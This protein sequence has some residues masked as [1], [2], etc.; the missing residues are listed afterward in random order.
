MS[1][2]ASI[3]VYAVMFALALVLC[4]CVCLPSGLPF[5]EYQEYTSAVNLIQGDAMFTDYQQAKYRVIDTENINDVASAIKARL[6]SIYG[7]Y[8]SNVQVD[9][10]EIIVNVPVTANANNTSASSI[11]SAVTTTGKVEIT[12][13]STY[14]SSV[15]VLTSEHFKSASFRRYTDSSTLYYVVTVN[16]NSEGVEAASSSLTVATSST[17]GYLAIDETVNSSSYGVYYTAE[18]TIQIYTVSDSYGKNLVG[19]INSGALGSALVEIPMDNSEEPNIVE[20]NGGLI[21][22]IV[23]AVVILANWIFYFAKYGKLAFAPILS[24]LIAVVVFI[25]FAGYVYFALLNIASAIGILLGYALMSVFTVLV[26]ERIAAYSADK[27]TFSTSRHKGFGDFNKWN[28]IVHAIVLVVGAILWLIPTGVTAPLGN[29]LVY[30]AV[31][32]F[33]VTMGLNRLFT[34]LVANF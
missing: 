24:Q 22:G 19:L 17:A 1:K 12:S 21:F 15:V 20:S 10:D 4:V 6:S 29:A 25:L 33:C 30:G 34:S 8:F 9:G 3:V 7:Y 18:D 13:S 32:S 14:S 11:L 16:L 2:T 23:A 26:L 31:L 28:C 27:K 5:G